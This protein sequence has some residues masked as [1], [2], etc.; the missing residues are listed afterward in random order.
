MSEI[1]AMVEALIARTGLSQADIARLLGVPAK[2]F[3]AWLTGRVTCRHQTMLRLALESL[4][5][6]LV[7]GQLK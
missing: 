7:G 6:R 2:T 5:A 4:G 3:N 1:K